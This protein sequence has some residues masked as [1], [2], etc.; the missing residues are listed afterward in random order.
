MVDK[1]A[2]I[3]EKC[4][5]YNLSTKMRTLGWKCIRGEDAQ[6]IVK[7]IDKHQRHKK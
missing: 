7:A 1:G 3:F 4:C 6:S 2:I 5:T